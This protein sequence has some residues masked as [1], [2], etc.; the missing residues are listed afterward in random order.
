MEPT[1]CLPIATSFGNFRF[2]LAYTKRIHRYRSAGRYVVVYEIATS[3]A[4][5]C[6]GQLVLPHIIWK[7]LSS[8]LDVRK[9]CGIGNVSAMLRRSSLLESIQ[10]NADLLVGTEYVP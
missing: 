10:N 5:I 6:R 7:I 9:A 4:S 3:H 8:Y 2:E 1:V